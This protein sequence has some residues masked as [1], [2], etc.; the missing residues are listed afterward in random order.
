[1][2]T[3]TMHHLLNTLPAGT[4]I[5]VAGFAVYATPETLCKAWEQGRPMDCF[6]VRLDRQNRI[7]ACN[8]RTGKMRRPWWG[9][10]LPLEQ[11]AL[12]VQHNARAER[13][14]LATEAR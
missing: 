5:A 12:H 2:T 14:T 7:R 13:L 8:P 3:T 9:T 10:I 6:A 1:M 4:L 11:Q